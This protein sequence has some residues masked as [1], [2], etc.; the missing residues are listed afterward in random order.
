MR[1]PP[2]V[3]TLSLTFADGTVG[4]M[5]FVTREYFPDGS[6]RWDRPAT[7]EAIAEEV[8][9][10]EPSLDAA[11]V[12]VA[13]VRR[14]DPRDVPADRTFRNALRDD[15]RT[16]RHDMPHARELHRAAIRHARISRLAEL[17]AAYLRADEAGDQAEKKRVAQRKQ[18]LRDLPA[19][20]DI[21]AAQTADELKAFWPQEL[22]P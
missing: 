15:G 16:L 18:R 5:S 4:I 9:R 1:R 13:A 3:V 19:H 14:V 12:P 22:L 17:D 10:T 2:D 8:R 7:V 20:P 21:E 11:K 6:V